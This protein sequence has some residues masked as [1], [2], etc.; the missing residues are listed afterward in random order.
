MLRERCDN[1][2]YSYSA[3]MVGWY[4]VYFA[5][6]MMPNN[7]LKPFHEPGTFIVAS[8]TPPAGGGEETG[9]GGGESFGSPGVWIGVTT[10]SA[11][12]GVSFLPK[13]SLFGATSGGRLNAVE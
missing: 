1:F 7:A 3:W 9:T 13:L 11:V 10:G 12:A 4:A 8:P 2:F 5:V 6:W